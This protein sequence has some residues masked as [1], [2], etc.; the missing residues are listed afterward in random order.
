MRPLMAT[1]L[2]AAEVRRP[3]WRY[4]ETTGVSVGPDGRPLA[5]VD[6]EAETLTKVVGE[7]ADDERIWALETVT[8][9]V[10][11]PAD[12][13]RVWITA[14]LGMALPPADDASTGLVSF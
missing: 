12:D 10:D 1:V 11:E 3:P 14:T 13:E 8:R 2:T 4:D 7:P 5:L 9:V 6:L